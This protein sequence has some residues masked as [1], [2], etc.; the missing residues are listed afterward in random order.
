MQPAQK[1]WLSKEGGGGDGGGVVGGLRSSLA[2]GASLPAPSTK[3]MNNYMGIGIDAKVALEFHQMRDQVPFR[4]AGPRLSASMLPG[5]RHWNLLSA[6]HCACPLHHDRLYRCYGVVQSCMQACGTL[7]VTS[8][9]VDCGA[10]P[11]VVQLAVRQQAVVHG[12][13]REGDPGPHVPQPAAPPQGGSVRALSAC[14]VA[15]VVKHAAPGTCTWS[16][17]AW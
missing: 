11:G 7:C 14:A 13:R 6:V 1:A 9:L 17:R 2:G 16:K 8:L 10:V 5:F 12:R 15:A 4:A 3:A